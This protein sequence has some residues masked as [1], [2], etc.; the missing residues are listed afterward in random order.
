MTVTQSELER[1]RTFTYASENA[2]ELARQLLRL[3]E[4]IEQE[5]A[6]LRLAM[7]RCDPG[8]TGEGRAVETYLREAGELE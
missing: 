1:L 4:T 6:L 5:R 2:N 8:S 7:D 3:I